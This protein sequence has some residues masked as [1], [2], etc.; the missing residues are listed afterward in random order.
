[1]DVAAG[2]EALER[3]F[4]RGSTDC[5]KMLDGIKMEEGPLRSGATTL[6]VLLGEWRPLPSRGGERPRSR[7]GNDPISLGGWRLG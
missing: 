4:S 3:C 1:M 6:G 2:P 7:R 5:A